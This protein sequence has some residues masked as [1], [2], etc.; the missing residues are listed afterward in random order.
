VLVVD[1]VAIPRDVRFEDVGGLVGDLDRPL[2]PALVLERGVGV[3][4]VME[5]D[6][7]RFARL[8]VANI[9]CP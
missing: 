6:V 9:E 1:G 3:R 7:G 5:L 4:A 2:A 8:D